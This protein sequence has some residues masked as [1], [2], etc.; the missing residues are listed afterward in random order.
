MFFRDLMIFFQIVAIS[1]DLTIN[2]SN[3]RSLILNRTGFATRLLSFIITFTSSARRSIFHTSV[4]VIRKINWLLNF[5]SSAS[6][7]HQ[8]KRLTKTLSK[9]GLL[10]WL[11]RTNLRRKSINVAFQR[12]HIRRTFQF[13][14]RTR[15]R[16]SQ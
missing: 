3:A 15:R 9:Q 5:T 1:I 6:R 8:R 4:F 12:G 7:F 11:F 13:F 16:V 2:L 10:R 14:H